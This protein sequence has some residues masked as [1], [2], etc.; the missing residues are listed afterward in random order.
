MVIS[1]PRF[2][3]VGFTSDKEIFE[4]HKAP[5]TSLLHIEDQPNTPISLPPLESY[6]PIALEL[7][8]SCIASTLA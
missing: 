4:T 2:P 8:E 1:G 5:H 7:E 6:D 3:K